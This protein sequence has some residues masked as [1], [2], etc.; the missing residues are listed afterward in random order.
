MPPSLL[1]FPVSYIPASSRIWFLSIWAAQEAVPDSRFVL[2][3]GNPSQKGESSE[4]PV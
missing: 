1:V 3:D 2:V 4:E